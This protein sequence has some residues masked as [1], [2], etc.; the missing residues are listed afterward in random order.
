MTGDM[1]HQP[2][3]ENGQFVSIGTLFEREKAAHERDHE[4][5]RIVARE[6]AQRLER[7]VEQTA[8]RLERVV[9]ETAVRIEKAVEVALRAVSATAVVHADAH[10]KEHQAH[11][12]IHGVEKTQVDKALAN[13]AETTH[14]HNI[15]HKEQHDSH[16][17]VH[18]VEKGQ[19]EKAEGSMNLRLGSMN[20]FRRT[21]Q[22]QSAAMVT[23]ELFDAAM[24]EQAARTE[25]RATTMDERFKALEKAAE[26]ARGRSE[27]LTSTAK[28]VVGAV[29]LAAA[30]VTTVATVLA[31]N[32]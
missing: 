3:D 30:V 13:E 28:I 22:D 26:Q 29:G 25:I 18:A 1:Q 23:R 12:R 8:G 32:G 11:E 10:A 16:E 14:Q 21:L 2:R 17:R 6:T 24:K 19:V 27:G 4:Q 15:V 5:E 7:E 31:F 20:D 9:D